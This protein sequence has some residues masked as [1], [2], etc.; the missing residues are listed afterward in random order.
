MEF[1][2]LQT[3]DGVLIVKHNEWIDDRHV[4]DLNYLSI[5]ADPRFNDVPTLTEVLESIAGRVKLFVELKWSGYEKAVI[6][7]LHSHVGNAGFVII[8]FDDEALLNVK[9]F[10][11]GIRT[12]LC[13]VQRNPHTKKLVYRRQD[14]F[15][16]GRVRKIMADFIAP[17]DIPF[18]FIPSLIYSYWYDIP[19][20]IWVIND[21]WSYRLLCLISN[22]E[23]IGCDM[24]PHMV[25]DTLYN[26]PH[27]RRIRKLLDDQ[28]S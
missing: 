18:S 16:M 9:R 10:D 13:L 20:Y 1:D 2:V 25:P 19:L 5:L 22:V 28:W 27:R 26:H 21:Y 3:K 6:D 14:V 24:P 7:M 15:H 23:M 12:G 11:P 8:S 4:S 17:R